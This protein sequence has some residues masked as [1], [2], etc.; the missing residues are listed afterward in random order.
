MWCALPT[1]T[2]SY[3]QGT[4]ARC[5]RRS[6]AP[7]LCRLTG[8]RWPSGRVF[9]GASVQR[10]SGPDFLE[11]FAKT[12][13]PAGTRHFFLGAGGRRS[14]ADKAFAISRFDSSWYLYAADVPAECGAEFRDARGHRCCT[15]R[16]G[17][18]RPRRAQAGD[19]DAR[20]SVR[21]CPIS[22]LLGVGAAFDFSAGTV[23][24][25]PRWMR[26][27]GLEWLFRLASSSRERRAK[28][29]GI[30]RSPL[31]GA[32]GARPIDIES[33]LSSRDRRSVSPW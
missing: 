3:L 2:R 25:A 33:G 18:G 26:S 17:V 6:T 16:C 31:R 20:V 7:M 24:R 5:G 32:G 4:T 9:R 14:L 1:P 13:A 15:A 19:L 8:C 21:Q 12:S 22:P 28:R 11:Q 30:G 10:T 27:V 29:Y 23:R